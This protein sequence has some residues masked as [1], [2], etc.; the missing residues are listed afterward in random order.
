MKLDIDN[1]ND[2]QNR[3]IG[4]TIDHTSR[5]DKVLFFADSHFWFLITFSTH[6]AYICFCMLTYKPTRRQEQ[7]SAIVSAH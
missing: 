1:Y 6:I 3:L 7:N 5:P 4:M 2:S